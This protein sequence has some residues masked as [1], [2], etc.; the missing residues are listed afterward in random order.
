MAPVQREHQDGSISL[1]PVSLLRRLTEVFVIYTVMR[2]KISVCVFYSI[3]SWFLTSM[4]RTAMGEYH[5]QS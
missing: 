2:K 5:W 1:Y 4:I 3:G